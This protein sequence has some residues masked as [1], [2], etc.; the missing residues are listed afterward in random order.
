MTAICRCFLSCFLLIFLMLSSCRPSQVQLK[1]PEL[2]RI[3]SLESAM[4]TA[5]QK[6]PQE[7]D[8]NLAMHLAKAYQDYAAGHPEDSLSPKFLFRAGQVI[9]N[10][11]DDKGRALELYYSVYR[12]YPKS[13]YAPF[14]LF[15]T[16]NLHHSI[17]DSANTVNMLNL[18][19]AKYPEHSLKADAAAMIASFGALPDTVSSS[20]V[21]P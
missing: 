5:E 21:I 17:R 4:K 18:F 3:D 1:N 8:L 15:M 14:A 7:P 16:G 20:A 11:F 12:K 6:A 2:S 10:V 9:E 19:L 13:G